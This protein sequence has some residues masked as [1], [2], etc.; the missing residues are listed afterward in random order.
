MLTLFLFGYI[1]KSLEVFVMGLFDAGEKPAELNKKVV[2]GGVI[3]AAL[4]T[5]AGLG[6]W[7]GRAQKPAPVIPAQ[8]ASAASIAPAPPV[9]VPPAK[10]AAVHHRRKKRLHRPAAHKRRREKQG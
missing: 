8:A 1:V 6:L 5:A 10:K 9:V 2:W 4:L 7:S 3:A